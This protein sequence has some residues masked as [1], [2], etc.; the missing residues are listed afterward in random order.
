[1]TNKNE[2]MIIISATIPEPI[3]EDFTALC[4]RNRR[5]VSA[6]LTLL[7]EA[8]LRNEEDAIDAEVAKLRK[9]NVNYIPAEQFW[10]DV[11]AD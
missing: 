8:A 1:M 6:Q 2:K 7:M 10:A 11:E 5:S 3:A 9:S 4:Q